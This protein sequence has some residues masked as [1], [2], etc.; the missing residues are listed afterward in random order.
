MT[1]GLLTSLCIFGSFVLPTHA[2]EQ[3]ESPLFSL[4]AKIGFGTPPV[5]FDPGL[6]VD[7]TALYSSSQQSPWVYFL[8]YE[9][10]RHYTTMT[11][12]ISDFETHI[13]FQTL[14]LG[15]R[16]YFDFNWPLSPYFT[17]SAGGAAT[18]IGPSSPLFFPVVAGGVGGDY[19]LTPQ[20]GINVE[21]NVLL[22]LLQLKAGLK[23][24]F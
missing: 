6:V 13:D 15:Y 3:S 24:V 2:E 17:L 11:G 18:T 7:I 14:M 8:N 23:Y 16:Y 19:M 1:K 12:M 21:A 5:V 4:E 9:W 10:E 20:I 22:F